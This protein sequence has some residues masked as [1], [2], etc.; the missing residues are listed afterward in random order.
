MEL[1]L[2]DYGMII[3]YFVALLVVG[4]TTRRIKSFKEFSVGNRTLPFSLLFASIAATY[5]GPGGSIGYAGKG[6]ENGFLFY[7]LIMLFPVQSVITG[8]YI[9]PRLN[10]MKD[11]HSVGDI[12]EEKY[13]KASKLLVGIISVGL[14]LGFASIMA[15]V[16][17]KMLS[18]FTGIPM[19]YSVMIM[20][21]ITTAY[22]YSG[23]LRASV[24][25]DVMQFSIFSIIVPIF[26][27]LGLRSY[28][29]GMD[30]FTTQAFELTKASFSAMGSLTLL[31]LAL[32]FLLGE[33]LIPPYI[34][35]AL[36]AKSTIDSTK[37]FVLSG[38][39]G[40]F[41]LAVVIGIG[42]VGKG[43][44]PADTL[45]DDVFLTLANMVLPQ[46]L[47]GLMVVAILGIIMSSQDSV[48][49]AGATTAVRDIVYFFRLDKTK[50][51]VC[52][53]IITILMAVCAGILAL[54]L[55]SI[56]D[57]VLI[58]YTV[59]APTVAI[60]LVIAL[61]LNKKSPRAG[62][63][64]ICGGALGTVLWGIVLKQPLGIPPVIAGLTCCFSGLGIGLFFDRE[65][66]R[67]L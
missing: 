30:V 32:T 53:K 17:G 52:S 25:T 13:G 42:L 57:S 39:F 34:N 15:M 64:S 65:K 6:F 7:F 1:Q 61:F 2:F 37:G 29:S 26:F 19:L 8:L 59:W 11:C 41:W 4:L 43:I 66:G 55:P 27:I 10:R 47:Y 62:L 49:N 16:G 36:S 44:V 35:R 56:I 20:S 63:F 38:L 50:E 12:F 45:P 21:G 51:L 5:I 18:A 33:M 28:P 48:I 14:C 54:Y 22:V 60:P 40:F 67:S 31:G 24:A 3:L 23:G 46:G 58:T 9:A